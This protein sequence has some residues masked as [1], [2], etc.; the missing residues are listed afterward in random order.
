MRCRPGLH[1][2][3]P[4]LPEDVDAAAELPLAHEEVRSVA[5]SHARRIGYNRAVGII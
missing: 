3:L 4:D 5:A 2:I 1:C